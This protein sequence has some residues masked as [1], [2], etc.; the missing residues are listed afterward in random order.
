MQK[1]RRR[2]VYRSNTEPVEASAYPTGLT[3]ALDLRRDDEVESLPH[4]LK[5]VSGYHRVPLFDPASPIEAAGDAVELD[6][7][8]IDWLERHR[9]T[10]PD[11]FRRLAHSQGNALVCCSAGKDRTGLVSALLSRLWGAD[12][13]AIGS[14]YAATRQTLPDR[15][16]TQRCVSEVMIAVIEHVESRYGSVSGYLTS[17]GLNESE[18]D[19]L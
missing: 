7:Q 11:V 15:V 9:A 6:E 12:L 14:D 1:G 17:L 16:E 3:L 2:I 19:V 8:Y 5:D 13:V 18:I 10:I 4:P